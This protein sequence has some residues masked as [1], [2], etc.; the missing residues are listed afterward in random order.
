[1][2]INYSNAIHAC[3]RYVVA[4]LRIKL[5]HCVVVLYQTILEVNS[6]KKAHAASVMR[7]T[8]G[9][10]EKSVQA[11]HSSLVTPTPRLPGDKMTVDSV[12]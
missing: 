7:I 8:R 10:N 9:C 6:T 11:H 2:S 12:G 3:F 5:L 4:V 1:M